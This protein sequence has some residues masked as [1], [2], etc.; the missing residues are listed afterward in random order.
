VAKLLVVESEP[1]LREQLTSTL[2]R[3]GHGVDV[4]SDSKCMLKRLSDSSYEVVL[5]DTRIMMETDIDLVNF[6]VR[7]HPGTEVVM[8]ADVD[9][10]K[11][12]VEG[13]RKGAYFYVIKSMN[14]DDMAMVVENA[15]KRRVDGQALD[16]LQK[17]Q[18]ENLVG[19]GSAMRRVLEL[20]AKVAPTDSTVL[21]TGE[22]GTGKEVLANLIHRLSPRQDRAFVAVSCAAL[23]ETLLESELFGYKKGAFTGATSDKKGLFEE[24]DRGTIFLDEV[25]E[26]ALMTQ[27]K[28]LRVLQDG[29][30]RR[31]GETITRR[32]NVR[33][34]AATNRDLRE[35]IKN[36]AFREDL[37]FRLNVIQIQLPPLRE[38]MDALPNLIGFF[39]DKFSARLGK[40]VSGIDESVRAILGQYDYPGNIRE[41][42]NIVEHAVIMAD[43][44]VIRT[45]DLPEHVTA[46][47]QRLALPY[48][49]EPDFVTLEQMERG[50]IIDTLIK[51]K[52]NQTIAAK[53]LGISRSTLWRK[54]SKH[55]I[56]LSQFETLLSD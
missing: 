49:S 42:E 43:E 1:S 30:L 34:I 29:E 20:V 16:T 26:T 32:V 11:D 19:T 31:V 13:L 56:D 40:R 15:L 28:L 2:A 48:S 7:R 55:G 14:M 54:V 23:P 9:D 33:V 47:A 21:L 10:V 38:R 51:C 6:T 12:A 35:R 27:V 17:V 44:R 45:H 3:F 22:T 39:I 37:Y 8:L 5:L 25:S 52:G 4:C 36:N 18:A 46:G 41:L 50:L 53:K 24:A